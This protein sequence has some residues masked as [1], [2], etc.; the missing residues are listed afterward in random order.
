MDPLEALQRVGLG[1]RRD[2]FPAQLSGGE[3]QRVAIARALAK[4]PECLLCD[5]PTGA[6]DIETGRV[7]LEAIA[8]AN[9]ELGTTTLVITH[10]AAIAAMGDRVLRFADG[11]VSASEKNARRATAAEL[12]W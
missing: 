9:R 11:R 3:Q 6:L 8:G 4:K 5:E 12:H 2:H 10:N 7:V 1:E